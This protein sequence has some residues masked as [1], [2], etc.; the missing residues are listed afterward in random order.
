MLHTVNTMMYLIIKCLNVDQVWLYY[1][2][3]GPKSNDLIKICF[4]IKYVFIVKS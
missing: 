4:L 1:R 3:R 2:N